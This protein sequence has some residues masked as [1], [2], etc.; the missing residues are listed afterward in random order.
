MYQLDLYPRSNQYMLIRVYLEGLRTFIVLLAY[1]LIVSRKI[2]GQRVM[3]WLHILLFAVYMQHWL[4]FSSFSLNCHCMF[5]P[6]WPSSGVQV[7]VIKESDAHCNA[8]LLL[9]G[10]CLGLILGYV[11]WPAVLFWC[12]WTI[13]MHMMEN[14]GFLL[15]FCFIL[16]HFMHAHYHRF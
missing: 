2:V 4:I 15:W 7:V 5:R 1:F 13:A 3:I 9:V 6:N 12:P 14:C 16:L 11:G 8:L 10:S